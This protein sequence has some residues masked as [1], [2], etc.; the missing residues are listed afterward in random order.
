MKKPY[1]IAETAYSFEGA[2]DYLYK[3]IE[4]LPD[5][6]SAIKFHMLFSLNEYVSD[7]YQTLKKLLKDWLLPE[8]TWLDIL[9]KAKQKKKDVIILADDVSTIDFLEKNNQYVDG[10]EVHAACV[11]DVQILNRALAFASEYEKVL[12]LGISGFE[13]DELKMIISY[14]KKH[15]NLNYVLMYGFQN[16]PTDLKN[17]QMN[18][19]Q[20]YS[21]IWDCNVGYADH[22]QA[23][24]EIKDYIISS[25]YSSGVNVLEVHYINVFGEERTDGITAYDARRL[26]A[27]NEKLMA[28]NNAFGEFEIQLNE[29]E[30][31][32]LNFR[33]VP[34][35]IKDFP[36]GHVIRE[37][38]IVFKRVEKAKSRHCFRDYEGF[39]N[40]TL[41]KSVVKDEEILMEYFG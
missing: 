14:I 7:G 31:N 10:I 34:V 29:G 18:K 24:L 16:Y 27:L 25:A 1:I 19:I 8:M 41:I 23:D 38:D 11:N 9:K 2:S 17:I 40:K 21:N 4:Q 3:S 35:F 36:E 37:S 12:Y 20:F 28:I 33:K 6:I 22:T 32:Y 39:I 13:F 26:I 5:C 30:L 15:Q